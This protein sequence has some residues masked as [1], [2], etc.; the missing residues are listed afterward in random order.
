LEAILTKIGKLF[1]IAKADLSVKSSQPEIAFFFAGETYLRKVSR[2]P[3]ADF[4][5]LE[6]CRLGIGFFWAMRPSG[7]SGA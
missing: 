4:G 1:G 2:G 6:L 3:K 5:N 7:L